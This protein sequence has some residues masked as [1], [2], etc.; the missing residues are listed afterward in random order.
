MLDNFISKPNTVK[1][2]S[3][4][5]KFHSLMPSEHRIV[6][7][8][9]TNQ[10]PLSQHC[11]IENVGEQIDVSEYLSF[12]TGKYLGTI[13]CMNNLL[14][15]ETKG[16][17]ISPLI[18]NKSTRK[19][20]NGYFVISRNASLGKIAYV[21][22][23]KEIILNGGISFLKFNPEFEFYAPAFFITKY[24]ADYLVCLTSGGG[25]QQNAK[26]EILLSVPIPHPTLKNHK[27]PD[28][29]IKFVSIIVQNI[30]DKEIQL[31]R[32]SELIDESINSELLSSKT[33]QN[34]IAFPKL[35]ELKINQSR[36]DTGLY[37]EKYKN[38]IS[39]I[40]KYPNGFYKISSLK[41]KWVSGFTPESFIENELGNY[42][43]IAVADLSFGL[44]YKHIKK[45]LVK[46]PIQNIVK[47]GDILITRKGATVGKLNLF[48][49]QDNLL[50]FVN[51]DL[52][53]LRVEADLFQKI[54]IGLFLNNHH[55]QTQLLNKGSKG[56]KQGLTNPNIIDCIVPNFPNEL[57]KK[58]SKEYYN[59]LSPNKN[60][61]LETYL[62]SEKKRNIEL[63]I[64]QLNMEVLMLRNK[65]AIIVDKII[66]EEKIDIEF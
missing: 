10:K 27:Q 8:K 62:S 15:D 66:K 23:D 41:H 63:G 53:V 13:S 49:E 7:V 38:V 9:N 30:L 21:K 6:F 48:F 35:S 40:E 32:K 28:D 33:K 47:D 14:F 61:S 26:R 45:F 64:F 54:F 3:I 65:L 2:S 46:S 29:V 52:K 1:I 24:G 43:W 42:W 37:N 11:L 5:S 44:Y 51:E 17:N 55:G 19:L 59:P 60:L 36:L 56:T 12:K 58:I 25:T 22:S 39:E 18:Y 16:E 4:K 20:S 31:K 34:K 57:K 50:A